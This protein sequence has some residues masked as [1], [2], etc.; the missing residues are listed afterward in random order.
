MI[1]LA[2]LACAAFATQVAAADLTIA[3]A[4][5]ARAETVFDWATQRCEQADIPDAP[6]RAFRDFRGAVHLIATHHENRALV[7][8][9]FAHLR[10]ACAVIYRGGH[11]DDPAR[12]DD[13]Q[14]LTSF[15]TADG[16][17]IH[18][19]VHDEFHG[20][21]RPALCPSGKYSSCWYN[22]LTYAV[23]TDGGA[24]FHQP[25]PP[26]NL[27]AGTPYRYAPDAG[28]PVGYFQPTNIV[29]RDGNSYMMFLATEVGAQPRAGC[30]ARTATPGE[31]AS[32]RGWN[33]T[34]FEVR[35]ID[36]YTDAGDP[37]SHVCADVSHGRFFEMGSL[38][39]DPTSALFVLVSSIQHGQGNAR[40][41]PGAYVSTSPDLR[42]W[43]EPRPLL[44]ERTLAREEGGG[45]YH[46][47]FYSLIDEASDS[48]DFDAIARA[49]SL[50]LYFVRFDERAMP[51]A[52]V[53][54]K[55]ALTLA[56][57]GVP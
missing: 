45:P 27:I 39:Y 43:S 25:T 41:P 32:W 55:R 22:A 8:P 42:A 50:F 17:T 46:Y 30:L 44:D 56:R 54:E 31:P 10:H 38:A 52:R 14:W 33:G 23:S 34:G 16:R 48:R 36:P 53:L 11:D 51:Y 26:T 35:F 49:P 15:A 24:S 57:T 7:G 13:R 5:P 20:H 28:H 21:L 6:A 3:P 47:G 18:A 29:R 12:Y 9:D 4:A 19:V 1:R 2:V 40:H 37:A